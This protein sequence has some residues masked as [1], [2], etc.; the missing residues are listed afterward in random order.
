MDWVDWILWAK[1]IAAGQIE[2]ATDAEVLEVLND[3]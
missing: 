1:A 2:T 3:E